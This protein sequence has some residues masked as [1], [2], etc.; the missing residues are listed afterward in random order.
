MGVHSKIIP[1]FVLPERC[2]QARGLDP[3]VERGF[4]RGEQ[5][6]HGAR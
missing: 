5:Q 4:C 6:P 1:T 3:A 2:L